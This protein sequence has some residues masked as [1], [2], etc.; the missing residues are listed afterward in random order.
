MYVLICK[1]LYYYKLIFGICNFLNYL[2]YCKWQQCWLRWWHKIFSS[3]YNFV[4]TCMY[5][6][7]LLYTISKPH[8]LP[9]RCFWAVCV[10]TCLCVCDKTRRGE[11]RTALRTGRSSSHIVLLNGL[12]MLFFPGCYN[13]VRIWPFE[14]NVQEMHTQHYCN[15]NT[16]IIT[17]CTHNEK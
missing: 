4:C 17:P 9:R 7:T 5:L 13:R 6:F 10:H 3:F 15:R 2:T 14:V 1:R 8:Q 12:S 11:S 16:L